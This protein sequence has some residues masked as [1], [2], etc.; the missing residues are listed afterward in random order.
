MDNTT[1]TALSGWESFYVV[2][3]SSTGALIG[4]QFVVMTL[5]SDKRRQIATEGSVG[6]FGT[7]TVVHLSGAL[8]LSA[9]MSAPWHSL[10]WLSVFVGA[11]GLWGLVYGAIVIRRARSQTAYTPVWQDW[12]WY[13]ALPCAVYAVLGVTAVFVRTDTRGSLFLVAAATLSLLLIAIHNAWDTV[14]HIVITESEYDE[15]PVE[16]RTFDGD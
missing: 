5:V 13:A 15:K 4:L 8:V 3:G 9:A 12:L 14:T 16:K 7:P 11:C 1:I 6:A 2:V 10:I